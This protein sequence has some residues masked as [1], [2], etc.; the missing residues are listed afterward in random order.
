MRQTVTYHEL[1]L[2]SERDESARKLSFSPTKN[3]LAGGNETGK[4][5]ALKHIVWALGCEPSTRLAG[6]WDSNLAARLVLTVGARQLTVMRVG[7]DNRAAFDAD[8]NLIFATERASAWATF[9]A[10]T[11]QFPLKLQRHQEGSFALAGP[12][13]ALL[14]F[15]IDQEGGWSRKWG[16]FL[17]LTQFARWEPVVFESF[18][19]LRPQRYFDAQLT[20]DELVFKLREA[21]SVA[22]VQAVAFKHVKAMLPQTDTRLDEDQFAKELHD[23]SEEV[24]SLAKDER[25]AR[26]KV[27][28]IAQERH[29]LDGQLQLALRAEQDLVEDVA[30]LSKY[31]DDEQLQCPTCG[32][33][34]GLSFRA[35]V[36]LASDANEAH[37]LV[38]N[39]RA[40][41]EKLSKREVAL[42]LQLT[43][44]TSQ[45]RRLQES[46]LVRPNSP[47][48]A[49]IVAAKSLA[50]IEL[51]YDQTRQT[52]TENIDELDENRAALQA[53]L[54]LLTDAEHVKEVKAYYKGALKSAA[55]RLRIAK[56]EI[57]TIRVGARPVMGAGS[58]GPRIYLAMHMALLETNAKYGSGPIF[59]F[60]V[61]TP[62]QQG[63]DDPNTA[64]LL[65][66]VYTHASATQIFIANESVPTDWTPPSDCKVQ[67]FDEKRQFLRADEYSEGVKTLKPLAEAMANAIARER[68]QA[69]ESEPSDEELNAGATSSDGEDDD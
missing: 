24:A 50:T 46:L 31:S 26:D 21:R 41:L 40:Q 23:V 54:D 20:R 37:Q 14:P 56:D 69:T 61:D 17:R 68:I 35:K 38:L 39:V 9:F 7:R 65:E 2:V 47:G 45:I 16:N 8:G 12:E 43:S 53:E 27:F 25:E 15:Y 44:V 42:R 3:L 28:E 48:V 32:Q 66:T 33:A 11:F 13:Y 57:G 36:E 52:L 30:Y 19:G 6:S 1:W 18:I 51:A 55:D 60:I 59:P 62:R 63:L 22:K 49:D 67:V 5:R 34:H 58:S 64:R 4:S 29:E 10:E